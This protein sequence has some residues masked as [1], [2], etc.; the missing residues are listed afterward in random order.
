MPHPTGTTLPPPLRKPT[1]KKEKTV[2]SA[3]SDGR[4]GAHRLVNRTS[5]QTEGDGPKGTR[6]K[7]RE[8]AKVLISCLTGRPHEQIARFGGSSP[9]VWVW[10]TQFDPTCA[11]G[12]R[13]LK[14]A[15]WYIG[16]SVDVYRTLQGNGVRD[17]SGDMKTS[18][19]AEECG[20]TQLHACV[21]TTS[22]RLRCV[23]AGGFA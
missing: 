15:E 11:T 3:I 19:G 23:F 6:Q 8:R 18:G 9:R 12:R 2:I 21:H 22:R 13:P 5:G 17:E 4:V 14:L 7:E 16:L 20:S 10:P 1:A